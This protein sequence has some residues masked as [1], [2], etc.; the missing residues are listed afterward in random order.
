[1]KMEKR[2]SKSD[3]RIIVSNLLK[4]ELNDNKDIHRIGGNTLNNSIEN[5][6]I[7]EYGQH[8]ENYSTKYHNKKVNCFYCGKE[9]I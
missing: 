8:Q 1:M 2:T 6:E 9:F 5:L 7:I 3:P 4:R